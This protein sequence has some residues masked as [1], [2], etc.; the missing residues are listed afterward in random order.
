[1]AKTRAKKT[2]KWFP[3]DKI[4][5]GTFH[6][7]VEKRKSNNP[8]F[9]KRPAETK[10]IGFRGKIITLT[11]GEEVPQNV[12]DMFIDKVALEKASKELLKF[13]AQ[14]KKDLIEEF[15]YNDL[16]AELDKKKEQAFY[17]LN[18]YLEQR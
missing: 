8:H 15:E 10:S 7:D 12:V 5:E 11:K 9:V 16:V 4:F 1:M 13:K 3:K 18:F 2:K 17:S 14:F 6:F